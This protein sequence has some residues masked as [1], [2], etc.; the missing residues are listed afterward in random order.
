MTKTLDTDI[1]QALSARCTDEMYASNFYRS[2]SAWARDKGLDNLAK[3][4]A[5]E[6]NTEQIHLSELMDYLADWNAPTI[7]ELPAKCELGT[8]LPEILQ[9]A[10]DME[11]KLGDA[12]NNMR[13]AILATDLF[14]YDF[15][16]IY[17]SRQNEAIIEYNNLIKQR[18]Q[19][20]SDLWFDK[21]CLS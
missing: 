17:T 11:L 10:Y 21:F 16:S 20:P 6:S 8:T 3:Y 14:T 19:S 7:L 5:E 12:Y 1:I 13:R 18:E 9:Y 4:F 2:A 15:L